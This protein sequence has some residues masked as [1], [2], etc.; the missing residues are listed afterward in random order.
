MRVVLMLVLMLMLM[1]VLWVCIEIGGSVLVLLFK[2]GLDSVSITSDVGEFRT[3][4]AV[5]VTLAIGGIWGA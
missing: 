5:G 3:R 4:I 1:L 2:K